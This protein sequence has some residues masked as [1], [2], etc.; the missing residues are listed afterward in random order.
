MASLASLSAHEIISLT[1]DGTKKEEMQEESVKE[2]DDTAVVAPDHIPQQHSVSNDDDDDDG[3]SVPFCT[4]ASMHGGATFSYLVNGGMNSSGG[5]GGG[6]MI[7]YMDGTCMRLCQLMFF[8]C[9]HFHPLSHYYTTSCV[10]RFPIFPPRRTAVFESLFGIVDIGYAKQISRGHG[11]RGTVGDCHGIHFQT[12]FSP[13]QQRT[14]TISKLS[15]DHCRI[16]W[17]ASTGGVHTHVGDNDLFRRIILQCHFG[18]G[19][20]L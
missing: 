7:M 10:C 8:G 4:S 18:I 6:G 14:V 9:L 20:W 11:V 1:S 13:V 12:S 2:I 15:F 17:F 3:P 16:A 5:G 19:H